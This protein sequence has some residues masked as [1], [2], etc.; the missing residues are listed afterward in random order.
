[1]GN[2]RIFPGFKILIIS[3]IQTESRFGKCKKRKRN[4]FIY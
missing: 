1:M 3:W 2:K 4:S